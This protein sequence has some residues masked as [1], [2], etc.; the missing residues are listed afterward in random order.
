M[1]EQVDQKAINDKLR[2]WHYWWLVSFSLLLIVTFTYYLPTRF[3]HIASQSV[4]HAT[5]ATPIYREASSVQQGLSIDLTTG[6]EPLVAGRET[7][8]NFSV[9]Q[10]PGNIPVLLNDLEV[11][12]AKVMHVLVVRSDMN[13][14]AHIH[15]VLSATPGVL[16]VKHV[17]SKP[18]R[19]KMWAEITVGGTNYIFG[20]PEIVV[21]G[22]GE[23]ETK[24]VSYERSVSV[25]T[26]K[27]VLGLNE[28][29]GNGAAQTL[30][31]TIYNAMGQKVQ[32]ENY[33]EAPMHLSVIK[34]DWRQLIHAH[35]IEQMMNEMM[36]GTMMDTSGHQHSFF[37]I[38]NEAYANGVSGAGMTST[39]SLPASGS[40]AFSVLFPEPGLYKLFAQFRPKAIDLL[41]DEALMAIFWVDVKVGAVTPTPAAAMPFAAPQPVATNSSIPASEHYHAPG[42]A[43]HAHGSVPTTSV[44][45]LGINSW[46]LLLIV[47]SLLI[48]IL[49]KYVKKYIGEE[50]S[51]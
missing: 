48:V 31:F 46:W 41:A 7:T 39:P 34:D 40:I 16:S 44:A 49:S 51:K 18:G 19:Y 6:T 33:L 23:R 22:E 13:E 8:F 32:V 42:S 45:S 24:Q 27:V 36:D 30:A 28:P 9:V 21:E 17:F 1:A 14:F 47:S 2:H 15:P 25:G 26:Y 10:K 38:L 37:K 50:A 11:V 5:H 20:E 12:H 29:I 4:T 35:P 43:S 3:L